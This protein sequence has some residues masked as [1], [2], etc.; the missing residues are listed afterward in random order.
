MI[1]KKERTRKVISVRIILKDF[2]SFLNFV[3][4]TYFLTGVFSSKWLLES[5]SP[6]IR[7]SNSEGRRKIYARI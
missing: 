7:T 2:I 1:K 4:S 3:K 5:T 6:N